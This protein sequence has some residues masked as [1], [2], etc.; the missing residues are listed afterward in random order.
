MTL[1]F[2]ALFNVC[3][4]VANKSQNPVHEGEGLF[5]LFYSW[6][7]LASCIHVKNINHNIFLVAVVCA[8]K[9]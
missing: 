3:V 1:F 5:F 7:C 6:L 9:Q 8:K 2:F 4:A